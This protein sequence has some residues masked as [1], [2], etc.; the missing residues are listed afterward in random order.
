MNRTVSEHVRELEDRIKQLNEEV[1]GEG[2][3]LANRNQIEAEIRVAEMH[4]RIIV[5]L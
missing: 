3:T 4:S 5:Q 2:L 1:M